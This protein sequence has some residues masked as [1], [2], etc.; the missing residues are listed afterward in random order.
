MTIVIGVATPEGLVL[1]GD[2]RTTTT[3]PGNDRHRIS[4]DHAQ[5]LFEV[6]GMGIATFGMAFLHRDTIA[7]VMDQFAAQVSEEDLAGVEPLAEALGQFFDARFSELLEESAEEWD[8]DESGFPL[9]FL[10]AGYDADG[11]GHILEVLI[12]T[13]QIADFRATTSEGGMMWRG[14]TDVIGR[15]LKGIDWPG[16][17]NLG[18]E[19]PDD[20][21]EDLTKLE[22]VD[23]SPITLQD[24]I[25]YACFLVRTTIDMQR[26]SDGTIGSPGRIPGCGG[27]IQILALERSGHTWI[28]PLTLRG[29]SRP[30]LAEEAAT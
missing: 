16:V 17:A 4:S 23:L 6:G 15:L 7:G 28:R 29:P 12:P 19:L 8:T 18:R 22:Y 24:G 2:S 26:F 9:G 3:F 13:G 1:A 14:Q 30:G 27:P 11:I 21:I 10:V 25:D 5:K 20:L